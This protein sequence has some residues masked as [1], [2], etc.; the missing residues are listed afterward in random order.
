M[1]GAQ[2]FVLEILNIV[3]GV[4]SLATTCF[5][6]YV[7]HKVKKS[8]NGM[9]DELVSSARAEGIATGGIAEAKAGAA[10][11]VKVAN[12]VKRQPARKTT[13]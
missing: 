7:V 9:K 10:R 8:V 2:E 1:T 11:A 3:M 13:P 6:A 12:E 5:V 4:L